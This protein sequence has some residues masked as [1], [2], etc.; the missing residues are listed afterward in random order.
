MILPSRHSNNFTIINGNKV[1][2]EVI[3]HCEG[4]WALMF[5]GKVI[6]LDKVGVHDNF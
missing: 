1:M 5:M 2:A 4:K 3:L 6:A